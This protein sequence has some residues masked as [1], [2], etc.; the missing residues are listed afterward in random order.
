MKF[1]KQVTNSYIKD[2]RF[3]PYCLKPDNIYYFDHFE[4][5]AQKVRC[6][7]CGTELCGTEWY[8]VYAVVAIEPI[9]EVITA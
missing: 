2:P 4:D 6:E 3:C 5:N 9:S 8:E 1:P 7:L